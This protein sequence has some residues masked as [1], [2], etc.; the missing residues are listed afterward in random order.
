[1]PK[2]DCLGNIHGGIAER[3]FHKIFIDSGKEFVINAS[4]HRLL[5]VFFLGSAVVCAGC[6]SIGPAVM[7][8]SHTQYNDAM[9]TALGS[10][11]LANIVRL[12]YRD[13]PVFLE[14]S[15]VTEN[16]KL[17]F[18]IGL[19]RSELL[20]NDPGAKNV[21]SSWYGPKAMISESQSPTISYRPVR[22]KEFIKRMMTPIPLSVTLG[23]SSSGWKLQRVFNTCI[24]KINDVENAPSA[25]G[26]MPRN[27][28]SFEK[29]YRMT[30]LLRDLE[31]FGNVTIGVDPANSKNLIMRI[32]ADVGNSKEAS[33]F[34]R[35][36]GLDQGRNEFT[37]ENNFLKSSGEGLVIRTRSLMGILFYLS[38][39]VEVPA[40]DVEQ[41]VVQTTVDANGKIFD[42]T[43]N[44]SGTLLKIHCSKIRPRDAFVST[45]YRRHWFYIKDDDLHSKSTFMFVSMLFDLQAGEASSADVAPMLTIPIGQ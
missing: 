39:A 24:E 37:F 28:P 26:P 23:M 7:K 15:S 36:L 1:M 5:R 42:W 22:G 11:L 34:K 21:R 9:T 16:W 33:E 44:A 41:G 19:D 8:T 38:H 40:E 10:Q 30:D 43:E 2:G 25:S 6:Q 20:T 29:F 13:I 4:M 3:I 14:I 31:S 12:K 17:G 35:I 32:R 27:K 45:Y 18:D